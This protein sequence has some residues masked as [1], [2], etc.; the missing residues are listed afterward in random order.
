MNSDVLEWK[1]RIVVISPI[2]EDFINC[3]NIR[4]PNLWEE[5]LNENEYL[6]T[7]ELPCDLSKGVILKHLG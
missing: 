1:N 7:N 5:I 6:R 3:V 2:P 4:E